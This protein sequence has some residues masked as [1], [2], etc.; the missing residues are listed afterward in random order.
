VECGVGLN[1]ALRIMSP[2][3]EDFDPYREWLGIEPREQP[4]DHYRLL[5]LARFESEVAKIAAVADQRMAWVRSFQ[6]GPHGRFTQKLLNDLSAAK[7]CLLSPQAKAAYDEEL[8][9][10]LSAALQPRQVLPPTLPRVVTPP[11]IAGQTTQESAGEVADP[12]PAAPWWGIILAITAATLAVLV[13]VLAW[14]VMN[15]RWKPRPAPTANTPVPEPE[16]PDPEAI[17][18]QPT[19]PLQE[20]SGEVTLAATTAQLVGG[21]ELRHVGTTAVLGNWTTADAAAR[22]RFRLIQPGFFQ[23]ELKYATAAEAAGSAV[24]ISVGTDSKSCEL[25]ASGGLDKFLTDTLTFALPASG[26]HTLE[27]APQHQLG[28]DWLVV[29]SVRLIPV[30][31][32]RPPAILPVE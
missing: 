15:H 29:E 17:A 21:V 11:P 23:V 30:G 10:A 20:G 32:A 6:V 22:W 16:T 4:A 1:D 31:G 9:R 5:G 13:V 14:G 25:R 24:E 28:G 8:A 12:Q 19:L 2:A 27:V 3:T 18:D 26:E 7:V